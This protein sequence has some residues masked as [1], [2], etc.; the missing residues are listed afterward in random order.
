M[1]FGTS[2]KSIAKA[3]LYRILNFAITLS[4][5]LSYSS[6]LTAISS[7]PLVST[8]SRLHFIFNCCIINVKSPDKSYLHCTLFLREVF[9]LNTSLF[10]LVK[11]SIFILRIIILLVMGMIPPRL[12]NLLIVEVTKTIKKQQLAKLVFKLTFEITLHNFQYTTHFTECNQ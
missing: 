1:S 10:Y 2:H 7:F 11:V 6:C 5:M 3:S 4:L 9:S 12:E 8:I